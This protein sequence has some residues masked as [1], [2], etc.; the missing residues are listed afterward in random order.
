M[1]NQATCTVWEVPLSHSIPIL[2]KPVLALSYV[3]ADFIY[4]GYN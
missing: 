3:A 2:S 4:W 1:R